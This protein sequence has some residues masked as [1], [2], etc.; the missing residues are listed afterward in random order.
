MQRKEI[1]MFNYIR[2]KRPKLSK[3]TVLIASVLMIVSLGYAQAAK[4]KGAGAPAKGRPIE[5]AASNYK[6][7]SQ[8]Q[9]IK[10]TNSLRKELGYNPHDNHFGTLMCTKCHDHAGKGNSQVWC[11]SCHIGMKIPKGWSAAPVL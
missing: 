2:I 1:C 3:V 9:L 10:D 4:P 5:N 8:A 6:F 7:T 11:T